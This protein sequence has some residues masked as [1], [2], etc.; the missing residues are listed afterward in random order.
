M[1]DYNDMIVS[2]LFYTLV[3]AM[4]TGFWCGN[5]LIVAETRSAVRRLCAALEITCPA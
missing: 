5:R 3:A 4:L 1:D 2:L